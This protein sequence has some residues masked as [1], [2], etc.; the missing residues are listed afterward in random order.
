MF[1]F[2]FNH[3]NITQEIFTIIILLFI[4]SLKHSP[5]F[6]S[7]H[8]GKRESGGLKLCSGDWSVS[9]SVVTYNTEI[10]LKNASLEVAPTKHRDTAR[11]HKSHLVFGDIQVTLRKKTYVRFIE[12][13][14][15]SAK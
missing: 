15:M 12:K 6:F 4:I 8:F 13:Q 3:I 7:R 11:E 1:L 9:C 2:F 5:Q 10:Y 14:Y